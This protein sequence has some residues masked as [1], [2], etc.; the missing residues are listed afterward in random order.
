MEITRFSWPMESLFVI[1]SGVSGY[2]N[3]LV[4]QG[5][6]IRM[7]SIAVVVVAL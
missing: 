2:P 4:A 5:F 7:D 1:T 3:Y 6:V